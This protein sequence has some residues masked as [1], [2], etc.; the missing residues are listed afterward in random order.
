M[1]NSLKKIEEGSYQLKYQKWDKKRLFL[2]GILQ[3]EKWC[4]ILARVRGMGVGCA[5]V[6]G[7][8]D[9]FAWVKC[10]A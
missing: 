1:I 4:T 6:S 2:V 10:I 5:S 3:I 8:G 9:V 7:V